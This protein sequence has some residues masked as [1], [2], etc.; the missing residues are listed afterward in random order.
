MKGKLS[1]GK[2]TCGG[3]PE[4]NYISITVEDSISSITFVEVKVDLRTFTDALFGL[5]HVPVEFELRGI[6]RVGQLYEHKEVEITIPKEPDSLYPQDATIA[7]AIGCYEVDGWIGNAEDC[8]NHHRW[9]KSEKTY[10]VFRI[11][12]HRWVDGKDKEDGNVQ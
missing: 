1:I 7:E 10:Q 6:E 5:G 11:R 3:E 12:Y 8:K 4:K 2:V 9:V